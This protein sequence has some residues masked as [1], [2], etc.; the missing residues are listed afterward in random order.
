MR[1]LWIESATMVVS[2]DPTALTALA[3]GESPGLHGLLGSDLEQ[4][5]VE[6]REL[7]EDL[8]DRFEVV[9]VYF[10][11]LLLGYFFGNTPVI[12][13]NFGLAIIGVVLISLLP[14]FF[15]AWRARRSS[16][17]RGWSWCADRSTACRGGLPRSLT[18]VSVPVSS[19]TW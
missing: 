10:Q 15:E 2:D 14:L 8:V 13:E 7:A 16:A 9:E 11:S 19:R 6:Y 18:T 12:K 3:S 1:R 5:L 17:R 4:P